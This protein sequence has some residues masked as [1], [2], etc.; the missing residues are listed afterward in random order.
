M[1][2]DEKPS[3][4]WE[5]VED[6]SSRLI[7][8]TEDLWMCKIPLDKGEQSCFSTDSAQKKKKNRTIQVLPSENCA[9]FEASQPLEKSL[10]IAKKVE[11]NIEV[12]VAEPSLIVSQRHVT[13][14]GRKRSNLTG[15]KALKSKQIRKYFIS[16]QETESQSCSCVEKGRRSSVF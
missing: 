4:S 16:V 9:S 1:S 12:P 2:S 11:E 8:D 3:C 14:R 6:E 5:E 13:K 10:F 7:D 15:S